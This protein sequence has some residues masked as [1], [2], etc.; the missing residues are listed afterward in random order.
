RARQLAKRIQEIV[1]EAIEFR[2]K[3]ARLGFV[4]I[5]D[6]RLTNDFREATVFYTVF[7]TPEE[8]EATAAALETAR[9]QIRT[10]VGRRMG[11]KHTPSLTFIVDQV[12]ET[13]AH[14]EGLLREMH[15]ADAELQKV[16]E[17]A[18]Y[19]GD[20]DPYRHDDEADGEDD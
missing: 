5:T 11:I 8:R 17:G 10:E 7:G 15:Q 2:V 14:L 4:T 20:A 16:R 1:A 9:G 12:P 18:T 3:D 6:A 19:A 13:S